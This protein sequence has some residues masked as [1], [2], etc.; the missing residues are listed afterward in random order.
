MRKSK[1]LLRWFESYKRFQ[2]CFGWTRI[3]VVILTDLIFNAKEQS[4]GKNFNR[5]NFMVLTVKQ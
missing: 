5:K 4:H 1:M 2:R 3:V